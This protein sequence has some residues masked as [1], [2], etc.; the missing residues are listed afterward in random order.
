MRFTDNIGH[1]LCLEMNIICTDKVMSVKDFAKG[2]GIMSQCASMAIQATMVYLAARD[3]HE[4]T[5]GHKC[6]ERVQGQISAA[7]TKCLKEFASDQT[8]NKKLLGVLHT[9]VVKVI[10]RKKHLEK[11]S[12]YFPRGQQTSEVVTKVFKFKSC[13]IGPGDQVYVIL[14]I[15]EN[16]SFLT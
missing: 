15:R 9:K 5:M 2:R 12:I 14:S 3:S 8:N 10:E 16:S 13:R 6:A 11:E 1:K 7:M 4:G